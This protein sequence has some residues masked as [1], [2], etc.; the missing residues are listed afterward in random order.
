MFKEYLHVWD[1]N[2]LVGWAELGRKKKEKQENEVCKLIS[3]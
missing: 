1:K 3:L 2:I